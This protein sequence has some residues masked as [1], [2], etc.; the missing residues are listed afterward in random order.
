MTEVTAREQM[1]LE[2]INRARL[3]P[4][5]EAARFGIDLNKDLAAGTIT[6]GPKQVLAL[7]PFL[8]A[9]A[10]AHSTWM[11]NQDIFSHTGAGNSTPGDRMGDAGYVFSGGWS[12]GEN[13]AWSG[14]T[15]AINADSAAIQHHENLFRSAGHRLNI[16]NDFFREAGVGSIT[17]QFGA[18]NAQ[19]TAEAFATSGAGHFVTGVVYDDADS[20][21]FYS[22]GEGRSGRVVE[23]LQNGNAVASSTSGTAGGY[24][25]GTGITGQAE[26]RFSGGGL[27]APMGVSLQISGANL[28]ADLV[29]GNTILTNVSAALT[30]QSV[31]LTLIGIE[32]ISG[33][34]NRLDNIITGNSG[35][36]RL[37]GGGGNDIFMGSGGRDVIQGNSGNDRIDGGSG[38][39]RLSGNA[40][41]D[42]FVFKSV[43]EAR[44]TITDFVSGSDRI[45]LSAIDA[46]AGGANDTFHFIGAAEFGVSPAGD[47][48]FEKTA[49]RTYIEG[50][51]NGDGLADF[52]I[53]LESVITLTGGDFIL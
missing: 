46:V 3:D 10:D 30:A 34:G 43:A 40:G 52:H 33:A 28:K 45:D 1:I 4:A 18:Y 13:I 12:W 11:L 5:G 26:L 17:G 25:L 44:D 14:T 42:Q 19:M 47:L 29:D 32:N 38:S 8:N 36:N 9:A 2:L 53:T 22:I 24:A 35:A 6:A 50:D 39:D 31:G 16:L 51:V 7:N 20:D 37:G 41:S 15:G 23:L 48:R 27:A 21:D 49:T